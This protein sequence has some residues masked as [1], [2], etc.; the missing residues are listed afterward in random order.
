MDFFVSWYQGDAYY[1]LYDDDCSLLISITSVSQGWTIRSLPKLPSRLLIDSGGFRLT[2]TP[3]IPRQLLS[4]NIFSF[5]AQTHDEN[6]SGREAASRIL[7]KRV[8]ERQLSLLDGESIPTIVCSLDYPILDASLSWQE[9]AKR[10]TQT[11]AFACELKDI[12]AQLGLEAHVTPMAVIQGYDIDSLKYCAYE[13]SSIG[14]PLYGL[15]SLA[16]LKRHAPIM[17]RVQTVASVVGAE[18]L[19]VFGVSAV[20]TVWALRDMGIHSI[21]S[22]TPAKSAAY[23]EILYSSPFRRFGILEPDSRDE[24]M[25]GRLPKERRLQEPL[26]CDCPICLENPRNIMGVGK[27]VHIRDRGVHNYYHL[28]RTFCSQ[29]YN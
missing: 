28:K 5:S 8:L 27:R 22:S 16:P 19:H 13:L 26:S 24:L 7:P 21:D 6:F 23:N 18:K 2:N 4:E 29:Q 12:V 14:F 17:E 1:P 15:G 20:E 25:R 9:K 3:Q 10:I 11:I